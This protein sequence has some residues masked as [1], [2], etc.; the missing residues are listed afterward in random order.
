MSC[1]HGL[2]VSWPRSHRCGCSSYKIR[3]SRPWRHRKLHEEAQRPW[4]DTPCCPSLPVTPEASRGAALASVDLRKG[5]HR[6]VYRRLCT[7][8]RHHP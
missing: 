3:P 4:P 8:W 5:R 1:H 6:Q 7:M 2:G